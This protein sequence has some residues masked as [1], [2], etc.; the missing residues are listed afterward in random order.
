MP[1]ATLEEVADSI[2]EVIDA[3]A[4]II[5]LSIGVVEPSSRAEHIIEFALEHAVQRGVLVVAA[6]GNQGVLGSSAITRHPWVIPVVPCDNRGH[7]LGVSNLGASIGRH[8]L[9][10]PG[11]DIISL[12]ASGGHTRS[13]GSSAAVPFVVGTLA[14]LWS[15][16][17]RA[18]ATHMRLAVAGPARRRSVTPPLLD[19]WTA[20]DALAFIS[21]ERRAP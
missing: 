8:G 18:S 1:D 15:V 5:N 19:A 14:L 7:V 11:H 2:L 10:A 9:M 12:A 20:Y 13:S 6:A 17:E 3:G 4:R 21:K 16:F